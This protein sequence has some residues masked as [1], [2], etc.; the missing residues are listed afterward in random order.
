MQLVKQ[1]LFY[2]SS[3]S[4]SEVVSGSSTW[5]ASSLDHIS[6]HS[7][8]TCAR[9]FS[10]KVLFCAGLVAPNHGHHWIHESGIKCRSQWCLY[11][12]QVWKN[13]VEKSAPNVQHKSF[14]QARWMDGVTDNDKPARQKNTTITQIHMLLLWVMNIKDILFLLQENRSMDMNSEV[15]PTVFKSSISADVFHFL[16]WWT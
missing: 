6:P 13:L 4:H 14:C 7:A 1:L 11:A 3:K 8:E 15:F 5:P 2:W 16:V 9:K 10:Q 12:W